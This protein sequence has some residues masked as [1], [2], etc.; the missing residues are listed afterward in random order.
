[1]LDLE[2]EVM[3]ETTRT[4]VLVVIESFIILNK[5]LINN[6]GWGF[7]WRSSGTVPSL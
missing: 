3:M 4:E 6:N 7:L 2:I 1:M 5:F